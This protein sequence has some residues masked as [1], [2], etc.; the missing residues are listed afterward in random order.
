MI[1]FKNILFNFFL[2]FFI[3]VNQ[4]FASTNMCDDVYESLRT[5]GKN[6][7]LFNPPLIDEDR[8]LYGIL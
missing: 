3:F 7:E 2:F 1:N 8:A 4:S 6:L 5:N